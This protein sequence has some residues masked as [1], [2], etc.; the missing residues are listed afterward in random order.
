MTVA[1]KRG[2]TRAELNAQRR[3]AL[4]ERANELSSKG[5]RFAEVVPLLSAQFFVTEITVMRWL[6]K[7]HK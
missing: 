6:V 3:A 4:I 2:R 1:D 7:T 5:V